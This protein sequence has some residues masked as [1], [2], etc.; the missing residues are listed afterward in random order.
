MRRFVHRR[1]RVAVDDPNAALSITIVGGP[2]PG[3]PEQILR[4]TTDNGRRVTV[5]GGL[6]DILEGEVEGQQR[7]TRGTGTIPNDEYLVAPVAMAAE[8]EQESPV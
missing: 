2:P 3:H 7:I 8:G 1:K 6:P 4:F 5:V